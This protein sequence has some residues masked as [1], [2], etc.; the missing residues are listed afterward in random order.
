[1][2]ALGSCSLLLAAGLAILALANFAQGGGASL[3]EPGEATGQFRAE[4]GFGITLKPETTPIQIPEK[5]GSFEYSLTLENEGKT[6]V[7]FGLWA[8]MNLPGGEKFGPVLVKDHLCLTPGSQVQL[9]EIQGIPAQAPPGTYS[10]R[11]IAGIY[12]SKVFARDDF[13]ILKDEDS[14]EKLP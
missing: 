14:T 1:M 5:G 4:E 9:D 10:F 8:E 13:P 7:H 2:R 6:D 11:L 12:P 3:V